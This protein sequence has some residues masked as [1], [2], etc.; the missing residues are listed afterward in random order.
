MKVIFLDIDGV[1]NTT[2]S[3]KPSKDAKVIEPA[4][5]G[6]FRSLVADTGART[7]LSSTW[8]HEPDGL[9]SARGLG[10]PFS[11]VLPD[12]RP[13]PRNEEIIAWLKT[14]SEVDRF[15][16]IDDDDDC[17]DAFPLFQPAS[18]TGLTD[19]ITKGAADYL[20]KKSDKDMR[21]NKVV[22]L[23]QNAVAYLKGHNG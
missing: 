14:H 6:R 7:V 19:K 3:R 23:V 11:D 4:L 13:R 21:R 17:L 20:N 9:V 2:G 1:L 8:R 15:V 18:S 22:R 5:L 10:V 16:V 12:L